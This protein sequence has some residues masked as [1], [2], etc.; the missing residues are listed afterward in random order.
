MPP[1]KYFTFI[2]GMTEVRIGLFYEPANMERLARHKLSSIVT[3]HE[4]FK[5]KTN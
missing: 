3:R 1:I 4:L 5:L 2:N